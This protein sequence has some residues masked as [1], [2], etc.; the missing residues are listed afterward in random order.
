MNII[1][2]LGVDCGVPPESAGASY[3]QYLDTRYQSS[4]FYGC[5]DTFNVAGKSTFGDNI[6]RCM[7]DGTWDFGDLRCEGKCATFTTCF[8]TIIFLKLTFAPYYKNML[9][10]LNSLGN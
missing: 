6:V 10:N 4:F 3:G 9:R 2:N 1:C 8:F 7:E 5:E